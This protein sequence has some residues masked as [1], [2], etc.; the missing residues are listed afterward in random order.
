MTCA[1]HTCMHYHQQYHH[2]TLSHFWRLR[3][4]FINEVNHIL[5]GIKILGFITIVKSSVDTLTFFLSISFNK[6][7]K[8]SKI[9]FKNLS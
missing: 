7:V 5:H 6:Y 8:L 2:Q 1:Q 9:L 4:V 3:F